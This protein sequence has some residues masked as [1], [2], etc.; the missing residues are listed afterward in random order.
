LH[1]AAEPGRFL[2]PELRARLQQAGFQTARIEPV[3]PSLED[4]F[5][6]LVAAY[7]EAHPA[8]EEVRQ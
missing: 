4:V 6:S 5:V 7:D 8:P 3:S 2:E 1:V